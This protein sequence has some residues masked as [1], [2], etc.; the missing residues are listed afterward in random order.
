MRAGSHDREKILS[1]IWHRLRL[2]PE[3]W[4]KIFKALCL[5]EI[6]LKC[7]DSGCVS[8]V[9]SNSYKIKVLQSF[10]SMHSG[11]DRG[12]GIREKAKAIGE[13]LENPELLD[14]EREKTRQIRAKLS[15][16]SS[17]SSSSTDGDTESGG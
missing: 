11:S 15:G 13:L 14:E 1:H 9:L 5:L 17:Y 16:G 2:E 10:S 7:G 3:E 12:V 8:Q 4:R 6:V